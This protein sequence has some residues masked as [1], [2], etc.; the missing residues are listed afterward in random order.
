MENRNET[1][2]II[3]SRENP[4]EENQKKLLAFLKRTYEKEF[5]LKWEQDES[6][7][8]GFVLQVGTQVYE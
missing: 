2:A 5:T 6:L 7:T 8:E 1:T 4:S 3:R